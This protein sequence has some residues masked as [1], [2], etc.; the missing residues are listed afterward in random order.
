MYRYSFRKA[1]TFA[2][3]LS[4]SFNSVLARRAKYMRQSR[5]CN[6]ASDSPILIF[7]TRNNP[8]LIWLLTTPLHLK[9]AATLPCNLLFR[10]CFA[11]INVSQCSVATHARCGGILKIY[12]TANLPNNFRVKFFKQLRFH[13]IVVMSLWPRFF[14]PPCTRTL[15]YKLDRKPSISVS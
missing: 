11:D 9:Y 7:F 3:V 8:F 10:A 4:W 12:L 15:S 1:N 2:T 6:F 5:S 13:R 14:S